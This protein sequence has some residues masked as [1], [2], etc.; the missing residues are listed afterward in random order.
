MFFFPCAVVT[1]EF[2]VDYFLYGELPLRS[3]REHGVC[4]LTQ[5]WV[6]LRGTPHTVPFEGPSRHF[7]CVGHFGGHFVQCA[8]CFFWRAMCLLLRLSP[9]LV[10]FLSLLISRQFWSSPVPHPDLC[11]P[12]YL[13]PCCV[14]LSD[15]LVSCACSVHE[16]SLSWSQLC[17]SFCPFV[18]D[19]LLT[20]FVLVSLACCRCSGFCVGLCSVLPAWFCTCFHFISKAELFWYL[21]PLVAIVTLSSNL[22]QHKFQG[23]SGTWEE[24]DQ[25]E[26]LTCWIITLSCPVILPE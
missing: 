13:H 22:S 1:V 18:C 4:N 10:N 25:I 11:Y 5:C 17:Q 2:S 20:S 12:S 14:S 3:V 9:C 23:V 7:F 24:R 16:P 15:R 21:L 6:S 26:S 19:S 8:L